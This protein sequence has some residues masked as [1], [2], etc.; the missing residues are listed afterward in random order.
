MQKTY[1]LKTWW[2]RQVA[3][4][5]WVSS[6]WNPKQKLIETYNLGRLLVSLCQES[7]LKYPIRILTKLSSF[8]LTFCSKKFFNTTNWIYK[9]YYTAFITLHCSRY[10]SCTS[11]RELCFT[12]YR[13]WNIWYIILSQFTLHFNFIF[14]HVTSIILQ[15][16]AFRLTH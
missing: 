6:T 9:L 1:V 16:I 10:V 4:F 7:Y 11:F 3:Y 13:N 14:I 2:F 12:I 5:N 8:L 15:N